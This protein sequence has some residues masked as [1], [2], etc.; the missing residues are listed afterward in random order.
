VS[1]LAPLPVAVPLLMAALLAAGTQFLPRRIVD[2][3]G[4]LTALAVIGLSVALL[5]GS[6]AGPVPTWFGGWT[7]RDGVALGITFAVDPIGAGAEVMAGVLVLAALLFSWRYFDA[8]GSLYHALILVY[9]G[10]AAGF[11][12]SGDLFNMFVFFELVGVAGYVLTGYKI[13]ERAPLQGALNF[14]VINSIGGFLVL[15]GIALLY[16]RTGALNLAQ[17]GEAL[18][19]EAPD[20]LVVAAFAVLVAGFLVKAAAVPFHFWLADAYSVSPTPVCV[21]FSGVTVQLGLYGVARVYWTAFSGAL[22]GH[23]GEVQAVLLVAGTVTAIVGAVMCFEQRHLRRL[24]AFSTV[25]HSGLLLI[26]VALLVPSGLAGAI[27]YVLGH[28]L[29]KAALFVAVGVL[30]H[31]RGTVDEDDLLRRGRDLPLTGVVFA[32]GGLAVA[33]VFPFATALGKETMVHAASE[34]G[35]GWVLVV[36]VVTAVLTGGAIL[37]A[38]GRVFLGWGRREQEE[39]PAEKEAELEIRETRG[40]WG[41]TPVTMTVVMVGLMAGSVAVGLIPGLVPAVEGAAHRFQD[42]PAYVRAVLDG[43]DPSAPAIPEP[44]SEPPLLGLVTGGGAVALALLALFRFRLP[45]TV[46]RSAW[47]VARGPVVLLRSVH[48]GHTGD[49]VAWLTVGVAVLGGA[50]AM[51]AG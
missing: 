24:L 13:D 12:L 15:V 28:G 2:G 5:A 47:A 29:A 40:A 30:L 21:L 42:R 33:G 50:L 1:D 36:F 45:S 51:S 19:G 10:G 22:G 11:V 14:A 4:V 32:L 9:A 35:H 46:R 18:A 23:A 20:G 37:R 26:G 8:S 3:A 7:P 49:Y 16:G 34:A 25:G 17:I 27:V 43:E 38:A 39:T 31:R 6:S 44:S 41:R 48:S